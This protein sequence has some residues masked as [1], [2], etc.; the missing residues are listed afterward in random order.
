MTN[1]W[2]DWSGDSRL[3]TPLRGSCNNFINNNYNNNNK[4]VGGIGLKVHSVMKSMQRQNFT[5]GN[6]FFDHLF[7]TRA[8]I[9]SPNSDKIQTQ[10]KKTPEV[11]FFV[12]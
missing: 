2:I 10:G 8:I 4:T 6:H 7:N 12:M 5:K 3:R 11:S 9:F 1:E